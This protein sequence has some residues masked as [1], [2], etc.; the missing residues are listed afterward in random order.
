MNK[1][2]IKKIVAYVSSL[3]FCGL[4]TFL[5]LLINDYFSQTEIDQKLRFL[6]DGFT[7]SGLVLLIAAALGFLSKEGAFDG[8]GYVLKGI[9]RFFIPTIALKQETYAEYRE[10]R[11][12]G[13]NKMSLSVCFLIC[14]GAYFVVGMIFF[15]LFYI[16]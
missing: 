13:E 2:T 3:L 6:C 11:H 9:L 10:R 14:G 16:V 12:S 15:A 4:V 8:V 7:V 1:Q 5:V